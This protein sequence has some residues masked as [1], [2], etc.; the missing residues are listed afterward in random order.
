MPSEV[1]RLTPVS[2]AADQVA[3]MIEAQ[4]TDPEEACT[5]YG[6]SRLL[7]VLISLGQWQF[8]IISLR[9]SV[10][11]MSR[12]MSRISRPLSRSKN[13]RPSSPLD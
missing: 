1:A 11:L 10:D 12:K 6:N 5:F 3:T 9:F 2:V 13:S 8:P 4:I 7:R